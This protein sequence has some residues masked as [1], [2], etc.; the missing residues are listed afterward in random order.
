[1]VVLNLPTLLAIAV[2]TPGLAGCLLLL[3]W[4]QHRRI[5]ALALWG[6]AFIIAAIA[7]MLNRNR[8]RHCAGLL[9]DRD[10]KCD[11]RRRLRTHRERSAQLRRQASFNR[12]DSGR[13]ADL[14]GSL[15]HRTDLCVAGS[16]RHRDGV[17]CHRLRATHRPR[18][19]SSQRLSSAAA[20]TLLRE[21]FAIKV[22][23]D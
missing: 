21:T 16:P 23:E 9:V 14:A 15:F 4:L 1:M 8:A 19:H 20:T 18:T 12:S 2:F 7:T 3:S 17:N 22:L 11:C 5:F 13:G 10:W 6:S